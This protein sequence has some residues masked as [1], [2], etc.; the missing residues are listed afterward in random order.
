VDSSELCEYFQETG[1]LPS[2]WT[3]ALT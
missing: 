2:G 3:P 1:G